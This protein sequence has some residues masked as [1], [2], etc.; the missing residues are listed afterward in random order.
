MRFYMKTEMTE[1]KQKKEKSFPEEL[2]RMKHLREHIKLLEVYSE[3]LIVLTYPEQREKMMMRAEEMRNELA[4]IR[5]RRHKRSQLKYDKGN[6][7]EKNRIRA[8]TRYRRMNNLSPSKYR[9]SI[10]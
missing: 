3:S 9:V 1:T 6:G 2:A 4:L 7:K 8:I 10:S 5:K